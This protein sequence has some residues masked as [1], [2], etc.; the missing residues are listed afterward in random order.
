LFTWIAP[1]ESQTILGMNLLS[2]GRTGE[3]I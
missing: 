2:I 3:K 1:Q